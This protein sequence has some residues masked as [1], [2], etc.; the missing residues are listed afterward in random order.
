MTLDYI[1]LDLALSTICK[2]RCG[3]HHTAYDCGAVCE[4]VDALNEL[5]VEALRPVIRCREC[6]WFEPMPNRPDRKG[7]CHI[8]GALDEPRYCTNDDYCSNGRR[9]DGADNATD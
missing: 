7:F 1:N 3:E 6:K 2:L 9:K 4:I 8:W 5:P